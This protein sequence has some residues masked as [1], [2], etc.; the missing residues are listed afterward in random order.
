M[1]FFGGVSRVLAVVIGACL[2]R[3]MPSPSPFGRLP[4]RALPLGCP[5]DGRG[6]QAALE[7]RATGWKLAPIS[8]PRWEPPP[9]KAPLV[10][11]LG[12][13]PCG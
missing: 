10:T 13:V 7:P 1:D 4:V 3:H 11:T 5:G 9:V 12:R 6:F 8:R 2:H